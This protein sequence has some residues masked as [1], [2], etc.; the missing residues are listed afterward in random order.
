VDAGFAALL[1]VSA[2]A[3]PLPSTRLK[4][5]SCPTGLELILVEDNRLPVAAVKQMIVVAVG[6]QSVIA[7]Q[8]A[9]LRLRT[10]QVRDTEGQ[11]P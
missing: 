9:K 11:L 1:A 10:V 2:H 6:A 7:P 3:D 4:K 8:L 5:P